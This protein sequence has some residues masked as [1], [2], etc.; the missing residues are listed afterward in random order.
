MVEGRDDDATDNRTDLESVEADQSDDIVEEQR[1]AQL[2]RCLTKVVFVE[3]S[4]VKQN[5]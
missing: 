1:D 4:A 5:V 3:A 2:Q